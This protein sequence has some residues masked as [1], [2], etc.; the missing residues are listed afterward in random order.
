MQF[1]YDYAAMFNE[2]ALFVTDYSN[3][4]FDF[5][6][7]RKPVIHT[8]FDRKQFFDGQ[9]SIGSQLFDYKESGFG[10]VYDDYE[11]SIKGI[12]SALKN[13]VADREVYTDRINKFFKYDDREN[14]KRA[15]QAII[16]F[17]SEKL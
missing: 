5:A 17:Q 16:S 15:L 9:L 4:L 8:Q 13:G 11:T 3:T 12:V 7:L 6:Y 2:S 1:P 10:P 14:A